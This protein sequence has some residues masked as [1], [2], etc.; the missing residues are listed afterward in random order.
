MFGKNLLFEC[1]QSISRTGAINLKPF[2]AVYPEWNRGAQGKL[3]PLLDSIIEHWKIG[4]FE[5]EILTYKVET[6]P[7]NYV[8]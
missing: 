4:T 6:C 3:L 1:N 2:D 8:F 5:P 7:T